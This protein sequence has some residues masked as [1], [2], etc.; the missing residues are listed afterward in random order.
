MAYQI[1][2]ISYDLSR[3]ETMLQ[4]ANA[5]E[6]VENISVDIMRRIETKAN[7]FQNR[8]TSLNERIGSAQTKIDSLKN[9]TN[10]AVTVFAQ[11]KYPDPLS[12]EK[13][14]DGLFFEINEPKPLNFGYEV[15]SRPN[16]PDIRRVLEEKQLHYSVKIAENVKNENI[17]GPLPKNLDSVSNLLVFNTSFNP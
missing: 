5:L 9:R 8:V 11:P 13:Y 1:N 7:E 3:E 4:I 14:F 10:K 12:E 6:Q 17:F 16:K 2:L 15:H